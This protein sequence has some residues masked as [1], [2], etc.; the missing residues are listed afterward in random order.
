M[1]LSA[2]E[3]EIGERR[4]GEKKEASSINEEEI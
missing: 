4:E 3:R 1:R 2:V